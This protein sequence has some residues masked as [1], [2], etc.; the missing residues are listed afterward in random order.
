MKKL[1]A[2][3]LALC[4]ALS[5]ASCG[6]KN[7]ASSASSSSKSSASSEKAEKV[8]INV[9]AAASMTESLNQIIELYK[10]E[11][12]NVTVTATYDSSGT[13]EKQIEQGAACDLFISAAQKQMNAMDGSLKGD[14]AKNPNGEDYVLQGTRL[15][16]LEN[17]VVLAVPAGNP[18]KITSFQDL[19]TSKLKMIALGNSDV[20]VGSY[21]LQ[22][23]KSLGLDA[24]AMEKAGKITYGSNVKEVTTQVD[25]GTVDCGIIYATDAYSAQAAGSKM[26][27]VA[28][29]TTDLCDKAVYPAAVMKTADSTDAKQDAA[30]A[31]LKFLQT[32]DCAAVFTKVG[33][34]I[35][36]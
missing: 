10:K 32:E 17:K 14:T 1:S 27:V 13:L 16:I 22:I 3:L 25:Q 4:M 11:A 8:E 31:F 9:F 30:K 34:T 21:S 36:K 6:S 24:A 7:T 35:V 23:L 5:L 26:E 19:K 28:T 2:L 33:F 18:A 29:A 20:P 12:P 15:D